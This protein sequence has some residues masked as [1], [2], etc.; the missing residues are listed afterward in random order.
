MSLS[1]RYCHPLYATSMVGYGVD[2]HAPRPPFVLLKVLY[3]KTAFGS[4]LA[5]VYH[6]SRITFKLLASLIGYIIG[7]MFG[8]EDGSGQVREPVSKDRRIP[9]PSW[10][11]D[12]SMMDDEYI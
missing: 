4:V 7:F 12:L 5:P 1:D 10:G 6:L 2:I 8:D 3:R 11:P 9:R